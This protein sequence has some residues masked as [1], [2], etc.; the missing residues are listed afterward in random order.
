VITLE[1]VISGNYKF[2]HLEGSSSIVYNFLIARVRVYQHQTMH[3]EIP[4]MIPINSRVFQFFIPQ[5]SLTLQCVLYDV[6]S[7]DVN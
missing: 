3:Q 4:M 7:H 6:T 2:L 1:V 5:F